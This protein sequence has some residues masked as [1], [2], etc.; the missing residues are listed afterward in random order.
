MALNAPWK[1]CVGAPLGPSRGQP[2]RGIRGG[3]GGS[4]HRWLWLPLVP[5]VFPRRGE[6]R[7]GVRRLASM[8]IP[9]QL[10]QVQGKVRLRLENLGVRW[11][12]ASQRFI[13]HELEVL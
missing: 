6:M 1:L 8:G 11:S 7:L 3:P 12:R 4:K 2:S 13:L 10:A 9:E 5:A